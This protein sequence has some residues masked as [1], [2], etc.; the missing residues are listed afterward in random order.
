MSYLALPFSDL[1][2][3]YPY[4]YT[5]H[6]HELLE[7][8][9]ESGSVFSGGQVLRFVDRDEGRS[10]WVP[11]DLDIYTTRPFGRRI[12]AFF[13]SQGYSSTLRV[14]DQDFDRDYVADNAIA[15]VFVLRKSPDTTVDVVV[16]IGESPLVPIAMFYSTHVV[17]IITPNSIRVAYPASTLAGK[18]YLRPSVSRTEGVDKALE[19][20]SNRG[21][22]IQ[23]FDN[24]TESSPHVGDGTFYC[25]HKRRD[26]LDDGTLVVSLSAPSSAPS[27]PSGLDTLRLSAVDWKWGGSLCGSCTKRGEEH[28]RQNGTGSTWCVSLPFFRH[29]MIH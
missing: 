11:G 25:P 13:E 24:C 18:G 17:N 4:R 6:P 12:A 9:Q 2:T 5:T 15:C 21:Y 8:M 16:S 26:F 3:T 14:R 10:N 29:L 28:I 1:L 22:D 7:L 19:K 27:N 23:T 20:Y